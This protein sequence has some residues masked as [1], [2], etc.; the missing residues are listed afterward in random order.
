VG[1]TPSKGGAAR[2]GSGAPK[3]TARKSAPRRPAGKKSA[4]R[5]LN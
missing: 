1:G 3:K 5:P 4:S 2:S